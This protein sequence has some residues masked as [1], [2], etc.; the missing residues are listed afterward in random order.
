MPE[1]LQLDNEDP[2]MNAF[3]D[4]FSKFQ[5]LSQRRAVE[6]DD[7]DDEEES[8]VPDGESAA[9]KK[10]AARKRAAASGGM[11]DDDDDMDMDLDDEEANMED[12][13]EVRQSKKK[14][15]KL[16]RMTVAQLKQIVEK[17]DIVEVPFIF[18]Y[19]IIAPSARPVHFSNCLVVG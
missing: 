14:L 16:N 2:A 6:D 13:T 4:V 9:A 17:P 1:V 12:P 15:R 5:E 10:R 19:V 8:Q 11:G 7:E 18:F 3:S